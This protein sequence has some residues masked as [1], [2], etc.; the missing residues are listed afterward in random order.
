M[1]TIHI[2]DDFDMKRWKHLNANFGEE[3][4]TTKSNPKLHS[5]GGGDSNEP[6]GL[7][8]KLRL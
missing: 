4:V 5:T 7:I 2:H 3:T 8:Y 1:Q 6:P